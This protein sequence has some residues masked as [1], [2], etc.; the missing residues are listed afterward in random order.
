[1]LLQGDIIENTVFEIL[2]I[3]YEGP[4]ALIKSVIIG[5]FITILLLV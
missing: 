5:L 1:M 4:N 3:P 2:F